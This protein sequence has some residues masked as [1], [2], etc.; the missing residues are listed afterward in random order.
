MLTIKM[1]RSNRGN[2]LIK[3]VLLI[4]LLAG[5]GIAVEYQVGTPGET[6]VDRLR[7]RPV[8][9]DMDLLNPKDTQQT[10]EQTYHYLHFTCTPENGK[11]GD[12]A[13]WAPISKF[14]GIDARL[15]VFFFRQSN[16]SAVR[17]SFAAAKNAEVFS[18]LHKRYGPDHEFGHHADSYG[19]N[20]VGWIRPSGVVA[21]NDHVEG[22]QES[23]LLWLSLNKVLMDAFGIKLPD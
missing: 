15:I 17:I 4:L 21:I 6:V 1:K 5:L 20:I 9:T 12:W 18:L 3:L 22:E 10:V 23:I 19:N 8:V 11:L 2:A 13:C 14:N 7:A 16:L